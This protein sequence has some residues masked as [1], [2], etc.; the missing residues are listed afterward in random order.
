[1]ERNV[2]RIF[3]TLLLVVV[4]ISISLGVTWVTGGPVVPIP[5]PQA[6]SQP[7]AL[8]FREATRPADA[9]FGNVVNTASASET[10]L[11]IPGAEQLTP[12][13]TPLPA[14]AVGR[15][16]AAGVEQRD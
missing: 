11:P 15:S 6:Q 16:A 7:A 2:A 12:M 13:A 10:P 14:T 9:F 3:E 8:P 1:M 5:Q 4:L